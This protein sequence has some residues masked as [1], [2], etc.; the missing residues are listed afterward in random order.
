MIP[1]SICPHWS[2]FLILR[3][4]SHKFDLEEI[5]PREAVVV[6]TVCTCHTV[7]AANAKQF[8]CV[9]DSRKMSTQ[10]HKKGRPRLSDRQ[11]QPLP[12]RALLAP[13]TNRL[14]SAHFEVLANHERGYGYA[15][16]LGQNIRGVA[17]SP[18]RCRSCAANDIGESYT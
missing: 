2:D 16:A 10:Q 1:V 11:I 17:T 5:L 13:A 14:A 6:C 8:G 4:S 18:I 3:K 9:D 7:R 15:N 12:P